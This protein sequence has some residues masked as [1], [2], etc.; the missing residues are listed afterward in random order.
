MPRP[1]CICGV[2]R[3]E[4]G[5]CRTKG[6]CHYRPS[7][8]GAAVAEHQ[9]KRSLRTGSSAVAEHQRN[10]VVDLDAWISCSKRLVAEADISRGALLACGFSSGQIE[11]L[12]SRSNVAE[13][14][15]PEATPGRKPSC[16]NRKKIAKVASENESDPWERVVAMCKRERVVGAGRAALK[17]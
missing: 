15:L 3:R 7:E 2:I 6:C 1:E 16:A 8:R 12:Q 13:L 11:A 9:R 4:D 17:G 10:E 14:M 5:T